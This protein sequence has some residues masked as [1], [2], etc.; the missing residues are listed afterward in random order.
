MF[1]SDQRPPERIEQL[2]IRIEE[3]REAIQRSRRLM[4]AGRAS[5]VIGPALLVCVMV[6]IINF[7]PVRMIVG[8]AL[9][10][11]GVVLTGSSRAS[12]A[13]LE[14]SLKQTEKER[15]AAIDSLELIEAAGSVDD[16]GV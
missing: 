1:K 10:I 4:L 16:P 2:E 7:T 12:T 13:Q 3:L 11:G 14:L 9:A 15:S 6:G 5:A 8:L